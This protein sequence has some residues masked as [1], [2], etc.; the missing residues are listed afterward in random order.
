MFPSDFRNFLCN[1][2]SDVWKIISYESEDLSEILLM[3][4]LVLR[5]VLANFL[6]TD[7]SKVV[8]FNTVKWI[9]LAHVRC[10]SKLRL[11]GTLNNK[12]TGLSV[13]YTNFQKK[14]MINNKADP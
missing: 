7:P 2:V 12:Q 8:D 4:F 1:K 6:R 5:E 10:L 14:Y 3:R 11:I 13:Y 9:C